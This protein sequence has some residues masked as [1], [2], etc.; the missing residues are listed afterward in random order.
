MIEHVAIGLARPQLIS[1]H[2]VQQCHGFASQRMDHMPIIDH[3]TVLA[4]PSR[5]TPYEGEHTRAA[6]EQLHPVV[7][8]AGA[9]TVTD[10]ARGYRI[11]YLAQNE[12]PR[13][14]DVDQLLLVVGGA[15]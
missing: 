4:V 3:M 15:I 1:I 2:E 6:E 12:A 14:A 9:W 10:E 13:G 11:K 5:P 8:Q 7:K